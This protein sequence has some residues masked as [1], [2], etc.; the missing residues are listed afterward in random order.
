M[1]NLNLSDKISRLLP[2][3][4][5]D[6]LEKAR[7]L[8]AKRGERLYI[9]GGIVR[10][11]LLEKKG[12]DLDLTVEGDAISFVR[13]LIEKDALKVTIHERFKTAKVKWK[14]H[15]IDIA[16]AR[17]ESY[18]RPGALPTVEPGSIEDDLFRRDFTINA[19]AIDLSPDNYGQLVD[20]YGGLMDIKDNL[21]RFLHIGSFRDDATRIWRALRYEQRLGFNLEYNTQRMLKRDIA[22]LK[23]VSSNR[24]RYELECIFKEEKPE[25]VFMRAQKLGVLGSF[26]P[27]LKGDDW[28]KEKFSRARAITYPEPPSVGVY[29]SLLF[30]RLNDHE[31]EDII[32]ELK[33]TK[34][35][36]KV[37]RDARRM[38]A[39]FDDLK[40]RK[41]KPSRIY[42]I[43]ADYTADALVVSQAV[44]NSAA[45]QGSIKLFKDKL[46][47]TRPCL[48]GSDLIKAGLNQ[49]PGVR[50][51]LLKLLYARLDGQVKTR[52]DELR[53]VK[54]WLAVKRSS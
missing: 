17:R 4:L 23:I 48:K 34:V 28:L 46:S 3:D 25:K 14:D 39:E 47:K 7:T 40:G 42:S 20:F 5:L 6:F 43:L 44:Q 26:R 22:M 31:Q 24:I 21:I 37:L 27:A 32:S 52:E 35:E 1:N 45:V 19:M 8:A 9:V 54:K 51:L 12:Y 18:S 49:G 2:A 33:L 36:A 53:L 16:T 41:L 11:L 13:E 38:K 29:F 30:Y 50:Q 15:F 10:D